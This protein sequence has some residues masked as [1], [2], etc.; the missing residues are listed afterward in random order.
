MPRVTFS[1]FAFEPALPIPDSEDESLTVEEDASDESTVEQLKTRLTRNG[2]SANQ[3]SRINLLHDE[4]FSV[5]HYD[6]EQPDELKKTIFARPKRMVMYEFSSGTGYIRAPIGTL[7]E[8]TR[9][10]QETLPDIGLI[11]NVRHVDLSAIEHYWES[12]DAS[13]R[14]GGYRL[15]DVHWGQ[16]SSLQWEGHEL[17][18][19]DQSRGLRG[20]GTTQAM[21]I[22]WP[23]QN[24]FVRIWLTDQGNAIFQRDI[25]DSPI[26]GILRRLESLI[27]EH[28]TYVSAQLRR[29]RQ[30]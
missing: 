13:I 29:R 30:R 17:Q 1:Y 11:L 10:A 14:I 26:I 27:H 25:G 28:S 5:E 19:D 8:I 20:R 9:R 23:L 12:T 3:I 21:A 7:R 16:I 6:P 2:R 4:E 15:R 24:G 22:D 18:D